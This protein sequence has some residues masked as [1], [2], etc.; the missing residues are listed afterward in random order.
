MPVAAGRWFLPQQVHDADQSGLQGGMA[1]LHGVHEGHPGLVGLKPL[2]R[3]AA[4]AEQLD[5][6]REV[7]GGGGHVLLHLGPTGVAHPNGTASGRTCSK[8]RVPH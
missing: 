4:C 7:P 6:A 3:E 5:R 2:T 8:K 1:G